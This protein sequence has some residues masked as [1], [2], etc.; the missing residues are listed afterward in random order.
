MEA[1]RI[2]IQWTRSRAVLN[3]F[4]RGDGRVVLK[5]LSGRTEDVEINDVERNGDHG[6]NSERRV[7]LTATCE[8]CCCVGLKAGEKS[9][10]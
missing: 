6:E 8:D 4:G 5:G 1:G 10:H 2:N 9:G 3:A 7:M